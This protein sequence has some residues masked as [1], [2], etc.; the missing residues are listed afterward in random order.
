MNDII[1]NGNT[2]I[3][4]LLNSVILDLESEKLRWIDTRLKSMEMPD[5]DRGNRSRKL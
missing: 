3:V 2:F 4:Q 1:A 5:A